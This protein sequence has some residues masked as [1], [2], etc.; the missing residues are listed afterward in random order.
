MKPPL[1]TCLLV[2]PLSLWAQGIPEAPVI[3][4]A[5]PHHRILSWSTTE[6][7]EAGNDVSL[8]HQVTELADGL[9]WL[10]PLTG[11]YEEAA[12]ALEITGKGSVLMIG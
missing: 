3:L 8:P 2:L 5:G 6:P 11:Q 12:E 9:H 10:N 1:Y 4:E 7:A